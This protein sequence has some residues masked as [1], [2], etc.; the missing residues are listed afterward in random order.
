MAIIKNPISF[1][2]CFNIEPS[3][4]ESMGILNP[5]LNV[6]TKLFIDPV[7]LESSNQAIISEHASS[8]FRAYFADVITLLRV[9]KSKGDIAWR[10]AEQLL[11]FPEVKGNCLGYAI[12]SIAGSAFGPELTARLLDTAKA[13]VDL[14][15]TD[16]DLFK[17]LPLLDEGIGPDRISDMTTRVILKDLALLT[18]A[19]CQTLSIPTRVFKVGGREFR[20]PENPTQSESTPIYLVPL[21]IL[22]S[23]P[24]ASDW[25]EVADVASQNAEL[26]ERVNRLI[27]NIW[28]LKTRREKKEAIRKI[29][30]SSR[31]AFE[32][33]LAV[34]S[35]PDIQPYDFN[36]DP[37]GLVIWQIIHEKIASEY[38]LALTLTAPPT[39]E[40]AIKLVSEIIE[41]FRFLIEERGIWKTL[42]NDG[43]PRNEKNAQRIFFAVADTYCKANHIVDVVP[44]ADTGTGI[45]DFKFSAGYDIKI[46]VEVKLST[47][48]NLVPGYTRQLETYKTSERPVQAYYLVIDVGGMGRKDHALLEIRSRLSEG[49]MPVSE[50][51][52]VRGQRRP[53]ASR[54]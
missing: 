31:D 28:E 15:V 12:S 26:R 23:L 29:V 54:R 11:D 52:F 24:I 39:K 51:V 34:I 41:Q 1:S 33:L 10:R 30:L 53:S 19:T 37:E 21:D 3:A 32:A 5:V 35:G 47:N 46:L 2:E 36:R 4:L 16:P 49:T 43:R 14:G 13:I 18:E 50:I 42:W 20:L 27:G 40:K 45:V 25:S 48:T 8:S 7:L 44:E 38:P 6:D 9:S 22:R 17:L